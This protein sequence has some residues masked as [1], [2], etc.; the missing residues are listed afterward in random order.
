MKR[1]VGIVAV[2]LLAVLA[3]GVFWY[4]NYTDTHTDALQWLPRS[5][6]SVASLHVFSP[7]GSYN[8][9]RA[10]GAWEAEVPGGSWNVTAH[11][12]PNKIREYIA[13]L[14]RLAPTKYIADVDQ[15]GPVSYGLNE[16]DYKVILE[17]SGKGGE[18]LTIKLA[19]DAGGRVFGWNSG[20]PG[21]VFEFD[22]KTVERLAQP[23]LAFL[24]DYI[25]RFDESQVDRVQLVQPF[26]SSW[27]VEEGKSGFV[28]RQPGYLE[29]KSASD[30]DLKL[31]VHGL[32]LIRAK[33][34]LLEPV[35]IDRQMGP[36]TIRVWVKGNGN[37][38]SVEFYPRE[39]QPDVYIGTSSW[40][41][42]PFLVDAR[43]VAQLVKSAFDI[44][45]RT[46]MALDIG[47][48]DRIVI[49]HGASRFTVVRSDK[50]WRLRGTKKDIPGIDMS[51][52]RITN[53]KF[54]ALPLNVQSSTAVEVMHCRLS[55]AY[56][57]ILK[58]LTFYADSELPQGQCWMKSEDGMY[59]PVSSRLLRDL[60]GMFP[61]ARVGRE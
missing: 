10:D 40:L 32:A 15:D 22:G 33:T 31:Y 3:G 1:I 52:W 16:P 46:V 58:S 54:E 50:G 44:Q 35:D 27:L 26:G 19:T 56:G 29:G 7:E 37:P 4:D 24:D 30:A 41:T 49:D 28:F 48:V 38:H 14:S 11:V 23:A 12:K 47:T 21:M 51:L 25:F 55:D 45:S 2:L 9:F 13:A 61:A 57:N 8:L 39:G 17:F 59:Y 43:S 60:Q 18:P 6:D 5:L 36:L 34:L 53:L 42:V 20:N